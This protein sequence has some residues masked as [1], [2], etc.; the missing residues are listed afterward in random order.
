VIPLL[1]DVLPE[2]ITGRPS[3]DPP[4]KYVVRLRPEKVAQNAFV[5]NFSESVVVHF[6]EVVR[7]LHAGG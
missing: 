4:I 3:V 5:W 2:I 1:G 6:V 7:F